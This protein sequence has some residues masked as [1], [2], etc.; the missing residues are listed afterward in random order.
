MKKTQTETQGD[1]SDDDEDYLKN[2][3]VRK[4]QFDY[5]VSVCLVDKFPEAAEPE[6]STKETLQISIAPGEGKIPENILSTK[7]WDRDAFPLKHPDGKTNLHHPR[8]KKLSDQYYF[9]Q[10]LRNK[11][12][13]FSTDPSYTF[14]AAA[15]LEKKQLQSNVNISYQR[16]KEVKSAEGT[17]TFHLEDGFSVFDNIK[18]TPKYWKTA[19]V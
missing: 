5:D 14:A 8:E 2:D 17:S 13:R 19:R 3:V 11:D 16:G 9:V 12:T 1:I 7:H 18:N 15:Y 10:R 6:H 4:Y